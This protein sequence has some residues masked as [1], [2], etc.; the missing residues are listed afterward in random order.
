MFVFG[1]WVCCDLV[2]ICLAFG[3]KLFCWV[4][5]FS[6]LLDLL[7]CFGVFD[8]FCLL[9]LDGLYNSCDL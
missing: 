9:A 1:W 8:G 6:G 7:I 4:F 5:T 2:L 3:L